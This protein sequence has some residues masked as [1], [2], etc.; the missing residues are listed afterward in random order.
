MSKR[1]QTKEALS[2][3]CR[4]I[5]IILFYPLNWMAPKIS[6][7]ESATIEQFL[8][9]NEQCRRRYSIK[10]NIMLRAPDRYQRPADFCVRGISFH[11]SVFVLHQ[12]Q[13]RNFC[14]IATPNSNRLIVRW[15]LNFSLALIYLKQILAC[16]NFYKASFYCAILYTQK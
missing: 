1:R 15:F 2:S 12:G 4:W 13:V 8:G 3:P 10:K 14:K 7:I 16:Q 11:M 6:F 9:W 5:Q